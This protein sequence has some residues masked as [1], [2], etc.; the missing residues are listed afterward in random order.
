MVAM[1]PLSNDKR[2][3]IVAA[4]QRGE[5][6]EQIKKWLHVS[7]STVSRIWNRFKKTGVYAPKPYTGRKSGI[8][9]E[10]D[11]RLRARIK[12]K[13]DITL[14]ALIE[15]YALPLTVSGMS[16][17]LAKMDLSYKKRRFSP[18]GKLAP[19]SSKNAGHGKRD[20]GR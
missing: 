6:V 14:E 16:R 4:K 12:Q 3:D 11:Q 15:E 5:S 17:R 8:P 9:P 13:P 10:T 19:T 7:D 20:R 1:R 18:T 2:T